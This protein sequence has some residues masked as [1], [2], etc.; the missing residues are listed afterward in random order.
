MPRSDESLHSRSRSPQLSITQRAREWNIVSAERRRNHERMARARLGL[1]VEERTCMRHCIS[2]HL[3]WLREEVENVPEELL[4]RLENFKHFLVFGNWDPRHQPYPTTT[5]ALISEFLN[6]TREASELY[7]PI[8]G[9]MPDLYM[10]IVLRAQGLAPSDGLAL[11]TG[12]GGIAVMPHNVEP[13]SG[14]G[15]RLMIER[16]SAHR[17]D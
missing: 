12:L 4:D 6:L 15:H 9:R 11:T 1:N 5:A 3:N 2:F 16:G 13:F 17:L 7:D 14:A 10:N 8:M